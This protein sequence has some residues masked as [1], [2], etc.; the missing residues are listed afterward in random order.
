MQQIRKPL[1]I[2]VIISVLIV[3]SIILFSNRHIF[4][5]NYHI[6]TGKSYV[7]EYSECPDKIPFVETMGAS[8]IVEH[9]GEKYIQFC[10][11]KEYWET[12]CYG[13]DNIKTSYQNGVLTVTYDWV[14]SD[15]TF[16]GCLINSDWCYVYF[17]IKVDDSI[18][19][20]YANGKY[21]S[22]F[23][24]GYASLLDKNYEP[25]EHKPMHEGSESGRG[26]TI[27]NDIITESGKIYHIYF[28]YNWADDNGYIPAQTVIADEEY[29]PI[30][31]TDFNAIRWTWEGVEYAGNDT[32]ICN[33]KEGIVK[34]NANGEVIDELSGYNLLDRDIGNTRRLE[35][36][37]N[38]FLI[39]SLDEKTDSADEHLYGL[40]NKDL[41]I[42]IPTECKDLSLVIQDEKE[43]IIAEK[44]L[45]F[46]SDMKDMYASY[47]IDGTPLSGFV[48]DR[49]D[50]AVENL[51]SDIQNQ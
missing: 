17:T 6:K 1:I 39:Y 10:D 43:Y 45:D 32:F 4:D 51:S 16:P 21:F 19:G 27:T 42:C 33:T 15:Y 37:Y 47:T 24:G 38:A 30:Y 3:A 41:N 2:G 40:I 29:S 34:I 7:T 49:Y 26:R 14:Y 13:V 48:Y 36:C 23:P 18:K 31:I 8:Y 12:T 44:R 28:D 9:D 35:K 5:K 46:G 50:V 22:L 11:G 25:V 20:V